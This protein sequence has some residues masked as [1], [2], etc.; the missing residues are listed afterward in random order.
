M[1]ILLNICKQQEPNTGKSQKEEEEEKNS[2]GR[3]EVEQNKK[4]DHVIYETRET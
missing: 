4:L 1:Y 3:P 2:D